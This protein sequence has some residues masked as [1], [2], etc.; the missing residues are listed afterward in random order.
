M[1]SCWELLPAKE[2]C[3][4]VTVL[5]TSGSA[6]LQVQRAAAAQRGWWRMFSEAIEV[7]NVTQHWLL[8]SGVCNR[9]FSDTLPPPPP[10]PPLACTVFTFTCR[11]A[12]AKTGFCSNYCN[13]SGKVIC[14]IIF[15]PHM[16]KIGNKIIKKR[17]GS[18][19]CSALRAAELVKRCH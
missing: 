14:D 17:T 1:H 8:S 4:S 6:S 9:S 15:K 3:L 19:R 11:H 10:S 7:F 5:S 16:V 12:I 13:W 2:Q 18:N